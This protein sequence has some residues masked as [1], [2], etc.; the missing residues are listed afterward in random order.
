MTPGAPDN[1]LVYLDP[2]YYVKGG[3]LYA[4]H[5]TH[6]DHKNLAECVA[7]GLAGSKWIVSY[8]NVPEIAGMYSRFQKF[9]YG[10]SYSAQVRY[11]GSEIMFFSDSLDVPPIPKTVPMYAAQ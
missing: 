6:S 10:L 2:P 7:N 8:D 3:G 5:F 4:N 1:T 9:V 11:Q